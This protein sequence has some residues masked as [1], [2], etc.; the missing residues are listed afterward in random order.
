MPTTPNGLPYPAATDVPDVPADVQALAEQIDTDVFSAWSAYT[1]TISGTGWAL[2]NGTIAGYFRKSGRTVKF[3]ILVTFGSTS[4]YGTGGLTFSLPANSTGAAEHCGS[5]S[6]LDSG[7]SARYHGTTLINTS[8]C[9]PY[10]TP[11]AAGGA[12]RTATSS[13][14]FTWATSDTLTISGEYESAT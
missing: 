2:G 4:S 9:T 14:P 1:P 11:S 6:A 3:R 12:D 7:S 13:V 8:T 10:F 5:H